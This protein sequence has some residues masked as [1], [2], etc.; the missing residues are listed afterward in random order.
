[1]AQVKNGETYCERGRGLRRQV[2]EEEGEELEDYFEPP[3]L[4][5]IRVCRRG[6]RRKGRFTKSRNLTLDTSSNIPFYKVKKGEIYSVRFKGFNDVNVMFTNLHYFCGTH[7]G[8]CPGPLSKLRYIDKDGTWSHWERCSISS[9]VDFER[10]CFE[11]QFI[12]QIKCAGLKAL[13]INN[14]HYEK[15]RNAVVYFK[16]LD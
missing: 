2:E 4:N 6:K 14:Y 12:G 9:F 1:M 15:E 11:I 3:S 10:N 8:Q 13:E 7:E 5:V 16:V